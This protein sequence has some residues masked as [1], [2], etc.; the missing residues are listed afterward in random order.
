[1]EMIGTFLLAF[2][3]LNLK[4]ENTGPTKDGMVA[5]FGVGTALYAL[6]L[7]GGKIT[8]ACYNPGI[9]FALIVFRNESY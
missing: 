3:I 6:I 5:S 2:F 9:G 1:M 4:D 8:M 7:I